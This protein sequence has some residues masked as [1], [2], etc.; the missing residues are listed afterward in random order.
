VSGK[1][2]MHKYTLNNVTKGC[3]E[4]EKRVTKDDF[5]RNAGALVDEFTSTTLPLY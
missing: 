2:H 3:Q 1:S 5:V 4:M